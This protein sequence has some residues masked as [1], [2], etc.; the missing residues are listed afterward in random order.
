M[1]KKYSV[2]NGCEIAVYF[3]QL[4]E[5]VLNRYL[6]S[7]ENRVRKRMSDIVVKESDCCDRLFVLFPCEW[8]G[9]SAT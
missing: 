6:Y 3:N 9:G 1:A 5:E 8:K 4:R 7:Y 2:Q